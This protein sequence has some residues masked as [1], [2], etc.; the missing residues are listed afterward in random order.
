MSPFSFTL[1]THPYSALLR[2]FG[3]LQDLIKFLNDVGPLERKVDM[4]FTSPRLRESLQIQ[5]LERR[6]Q[7]QDTRRTVSDMPLMGE[8]LDHVTKRTTNFSNIAKVEDITFGLT[9]VQMYE[10][11]AQNKSNEGFWEEFQLRDHHDKDAQFQ[12]IDACRKYLELPVI[13]KDENKEYLGLSASKAAT[14]N[15]ASLGMKPATGVK[16]VLSHLLDQDNERQ[17][18]TET[19]S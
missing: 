6:R 17:I 2:R 19:V 3:W 16:L 8:G 7:E 9:G 12:L 18:K 5:E 10:M 11:L 14:M 13:L 15:L 4:A 1:D